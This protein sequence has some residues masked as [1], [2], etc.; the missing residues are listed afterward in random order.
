MLPGA[1]LGSGAA[2]G[3]PSS[4][5]IMD[6]KAFRRDLEGSAAGQGAQKAE[7]R[8]IKF[9]KARKA[10]NGFVTLTQPAAKGPGGAGKGQTVRGRHRRLLL[11]RVSR[12]CAALAAL[13]G[14]K[15]SLADDANLPDPESGLCAE[16]RVRQLMKWQKV[17]RNGERPGACDDKWEKMSI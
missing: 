8:H 13:Q 6:H 9:H 3:S 16:S 4:V 1:G 11:V 15:K 5:P 7:R 14:S 10:E 17:E 2:A 12:P